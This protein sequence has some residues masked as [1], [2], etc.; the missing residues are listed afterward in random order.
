ME[1]RFLG[2]MLDIRALQAAPL[3]ESL[4]LPMD[5]LLFGACVSAMEDYLGDALLTR[6]QIGSAAMLSFSQSAESN[7]AKQVGNVPQNDIDE[8]VRKYLER[9]SWHDLD[10]ARRCFKAAL[11]ID[12][13]ATPRLDVAIA[14]RHDMIHRQGTTITGGHWW[15]SASQVTALLDLVEAFIKRVDAKLVAYDQKHVAP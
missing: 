3:D 4:R 11:D 1:G 14:V 10:F 9:R 5:R 8:K 12:L 6:T 15:I 2:A 7:W 13:P